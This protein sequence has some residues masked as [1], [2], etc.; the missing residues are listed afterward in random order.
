[1]CVLLERCEMIMLVFV[2][3]VFDKIRNM[4]NDLMKEIV[5]EN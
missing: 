1:M 3:D 4:E 2:K 5:L